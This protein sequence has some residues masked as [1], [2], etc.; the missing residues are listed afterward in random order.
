[1]I[2]V[3]VRGIGVERVGGYEVIFEVSRRRNFI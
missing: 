2:D 1:M 3:E